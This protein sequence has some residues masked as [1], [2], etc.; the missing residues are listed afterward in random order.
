MHDQ[1]NDLIAGGYLTWIY[2]NPFDG[3]AW[4]Q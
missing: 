4:Y 2:L 1:I 3:R